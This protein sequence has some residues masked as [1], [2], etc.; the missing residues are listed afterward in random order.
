[1]AWPLDDTEVAILCLDRNANGRVDDGSEVIGTQMGFGAGFDALLEL[2]PNDGNGW[3]DEKDD[4]FSKLLLW[5]D[6]NRNGLSE[7]GELSQ[8]SKMLARIG[9]GYY[10]QSKQ[11]GID[12]NRVTFRGWAVAR[13]DFTGKAG[14][15]LTTLLEVV[16]SS[17]R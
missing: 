4:L 2:A 13:A 7:P 10:V 14:D 9:L 6:K 17:G 1:M 12:G 3:L 8:A 15:P 5:K 11:D 16:F